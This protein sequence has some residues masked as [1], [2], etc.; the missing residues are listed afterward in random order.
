MPDAVALLDRVI[1]PLEAVLTWAVT[2]EKDAMVLKDAIVLT[3]AQARIGRVCWCAQHQ[4]VQWQGAY[5]LLL[6]I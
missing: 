1:V 6:C 4:Q 3:S 2:V 5:Q